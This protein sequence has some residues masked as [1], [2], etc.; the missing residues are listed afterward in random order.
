VDPERE[1]VVGTGCSLKKS[2]KRDSDLGHFEEQ[3]KNT[4]SYNIF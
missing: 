4:L 1:K 2:V 3:M